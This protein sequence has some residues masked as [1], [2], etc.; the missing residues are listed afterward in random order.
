MGSKL[1]YECFVSLPPEFSQYPAQFCI[2]EFKGTVYPVRN[3]WVRH[4]LVGG[5]AYYCSNLL[6]YSKV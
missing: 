5:M 1:S 6:A 2:I 4:G 3:G